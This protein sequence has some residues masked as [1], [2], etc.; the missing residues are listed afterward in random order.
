MRLLYHVYLEGL[1]AKHWS[2]ALVLLFCLK[3]NIDR[4]LYLWH[5]GI[6]KNCCYVMRCTGQPE[7][8]QVPV[9]LT[10]LAISG[11]INTAATDYLRDVWWSVSRTKHLFFYNHY[12]NCLAKEI[13]SRKHIAVK[14]WWWRHAIRWIS[15]RVLFVTVHD[16]HN[17]IFVLPCQIL[18]NKINS[19]R[20]YMLPIFTLDELNRMIWQFPQ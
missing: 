14:K 3:G 4:I 17:N 11:A 18:L 8:S 20:S 19:N 1:F 6:E 5:Y 2:D 15:I 12:A 7:R 9:P 10:V 16:D 13:L